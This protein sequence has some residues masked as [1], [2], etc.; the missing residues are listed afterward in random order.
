MGFPCK[1]CTNRKP[2]CHDYCE[3]YQKAKV[4]HEK[5]KTSNNANCYSKI[6]SI[7]KDSFSGDM[8]FAYNVKRNFGIDISNYC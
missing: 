3:A 5:N 1:G 8:W 4:E 6:Y 2:G 7:A